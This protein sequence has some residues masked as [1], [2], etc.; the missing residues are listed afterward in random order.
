MLTLIYKDQ[1]VVQASELI[2]PEPRHKW[3]NCAV[4]GEPMK[5]QFGVDWLGSKEP[6][7][8]SDYTLVPPGIYIGR[9]Y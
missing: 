5:I 7:I 4:M 1:N 6:F 2:F 9:L 3:V 8:I